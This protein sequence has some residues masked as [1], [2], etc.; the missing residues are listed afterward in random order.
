MLPAM[1]L[2][3]PGAASMC[4]LAPHINTTHAGFEELYGARY[5][6]D[7]LDIWAHHTPYPFNQ[8]RAS[9]GAAHYVWS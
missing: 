8:V 7:V 1:L 3:A 4:R 9:A 2:L 6:V 5:H